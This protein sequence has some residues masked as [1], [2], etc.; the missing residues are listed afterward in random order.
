MHSACAV[1]KAAICVNS[2]CEFLGEGVV[3]VSS[4][5]RGWLRDAATWEQVGLQQHRS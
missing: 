4:Y 2:A 1:A 5:G 3:G